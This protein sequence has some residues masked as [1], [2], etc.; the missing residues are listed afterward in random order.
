MIGNKAILTSL[1]S[2]FAREFDF[3]HAWLFYGPKGCGKT[4]LARIVAHKLKCSVDDLYEYNMANLKG[5]DTVRDI[6]ENAV[7]AP[8]SSPVKFYIL[9]EVH[10]QIKGA[11]DALLKI[12][13]EPPQHV[14]F[15]LCTTNPEKLQG[16]VRSRCMPFLVKT[17]LSTEMKMLLDGVLTR[18]GL[19]DYPIAVI[20]E[21]IRIAEGIPRDALVA[22]DSVIDI[23][24]EEMAIQVLQ[25]ISIGEADLADICKELM[26]GTTWEAIRKRVSTLASNINDAEKIRRGAMGWF[27]KVLLNSKTNDR[28]SMILQIMEDNTYDGGIPKLINMFYMATKIR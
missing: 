12:L 26:D 28:V 21:I 11:Q 13:E 10:E 27:S 4:T 19:P 20:R 17:L 8:I 23:Q 9:D 6:L 18:E 25:N 2:I 22:L 24:N 15:A 1:E 7:Y 14:Y 5:I 16:A 3:P